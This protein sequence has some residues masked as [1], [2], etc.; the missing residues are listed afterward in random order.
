M[1]EHWKWKRGRRQVLCRARVIHCWDLCRVELGWTAAQTRRFLQ[2]S[3]T[4]S[5]LDHADQLYNNGSTS[6]AERPA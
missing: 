5:D 1:H 3:C 6:H 4:Q 2:S